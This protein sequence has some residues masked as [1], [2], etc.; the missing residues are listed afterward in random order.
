MGAGLE[1]AAR[2]G[3]ACSRSRAQGHA[4]AED[5]AEAPQCDRD[6]EGEVDD[7]CEAQCG[8]PGDSEDGQRLDAE[9]ME[10]PDVAGAGRDEDAQVGRRHD[11]HRNEGVEAKA[12]CRQ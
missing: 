2:K 3:M 4:V 7:Q 11:E 9:E 10:G 1:D 8:S 6:V 12:E 5:D